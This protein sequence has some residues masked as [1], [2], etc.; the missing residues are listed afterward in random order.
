[1]F[2]TKY[3]GKSLLKNDQVLKK[4]SLPKHL[5]DNTLM[6]CYYSKCLAKLRGML[7]DRA[8]MPFGFNYTAWLQHTCLMTIVY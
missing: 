1:M 6:S 3:F 8:E 5:A 4:F 2:L 7:F